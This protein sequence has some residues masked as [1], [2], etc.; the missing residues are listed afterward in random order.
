MR[1]LSLGIVRW[2]LNRLEPNVKS[3]ENIF[4]QVGHGESLDDPAAAAQ[5][6]SAFLGRP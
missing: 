4:R 2:L 1:L 6:T 3:S 5:T